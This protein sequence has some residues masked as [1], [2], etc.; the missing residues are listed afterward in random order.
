MALYA[1]NAAR[2]RGNVIYPPDLLNPLTIGAADA[3][4]TNLTQIGAGYIELYGATPYIDFH[5]NNDSDDYTYRII[6]SVTD[7]LRLIS[8]EGTNCWLYLGNGTNTA[9]VFWHT[10]GGGWYM[11]DS[12]Y[13]RNY[14][15]KKMYHTGT[16]EIHANSGSYTE[17][18]RIYPN[19]NWSTILLGGADLTEATGTSANSWGVF[20][21]NGSFYITKSGS[22]SG[23]VLLKNVS[24]IWEFVGSYLKVTANSNTF[25][26]GSQNSSYTHLYNSANIPFIF[27]NSVL[28]TTGDLGNTTYP[29]NNLYLGK[30]GTRGIYYVG[31]NSTTRMITFLDGPDQYGNGI[32]IGAGGLVMVGAG[33]S[34]ETVKTNISPSAGDEFLCLSAD[35]SIKFYPTQNSYVSSYYGEMSY[36]RLWMGIDSGNVAEAQVGVKNLSGRVMLW[37]SPTDGGDKG[38]YCYSKDGTTGGNI[39]RVNTSLQMIGM[40]P[41]NLTWAAAAAGSGNLGTA[42]VPWGTIYLNNWIR[43]TGNTG[44]YNQT[45]AGGWYM[46]DTKWIRNYNNKPILMSVASN[47]TYGQNGHHLG[48][49]IVGDSHVGIMLI[50]GGVG[51]SFNANGNGNWY[52]GKRTSGNIES[53]S[54]DAYIL[55]GNTSFVAPNTTGGVNLGLSDHKFGTMYINAVYAYADLWCKKVRLVD[56]WIGYY[57]GDVSSTTRYGYIQCNASCMYFRKE[58][59]TDSSGHSFNFSGNIYMNSTS[60]EIEWGTSSGTTISGTSGDAFS[61]VGL[62]GVL[63]DITNGS[64]SSTSC[65]VQNRDNTV[66][67]L[68]NSNAG[69]YHQNTAGSSTGKW[70]IYI[71]TSGTVTANT[72]DKRWKIDKGYLQDSEAYNILNE[73][74]IVNFIYKEDVEY[75]N[76]EQ[77]GIYA[78]D[79]KNILL[80]YNYP[81]RNYLGLQKIESEEHAEEKRDVIFARHD[82]KLTKEDRQICQE[83]IEE[84]EEENGWEQVYYDLNL[85]EEDYRYEMNYQAMIPLLIKGWQMQQKQIEELEQEIVELKAKNGES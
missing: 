18:L 26:L 79:L 30:G 68:T 10:F 75:N 69:V 76:L 65:Q 61:T 57:A 25:S 52:M 42:T 77:S 44:W 24:N 56:N 38:V 70:L 58:N 19:S 47:N 73:I 8:K 16:I 81:N 41:A 80:K 33:E 4:S 84:D 64:G 35:A 49:G 31:T 83:W 28:T 21:N 12:T 32:M 55:Y 13:L 14:N 62:T 71:S 20:N 45:H 48:L 50:G 9:G 60:D 27:N 46:A 59:G 72:S 3:T 29:F 34:A 67:L 7:G 5:Y 85:P 23:T 78:Q 36:N 15:G 17:G 40:A 54:G 11:T 66:S 1:W 39:C 82:K 51:Y 37:A 43:T 74:P 22:S 2:T 6:S 53:T 63:V